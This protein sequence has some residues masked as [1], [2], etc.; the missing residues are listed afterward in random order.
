MKNR[1]ISRQ[2]QQLNTLFQSTR[3]ATG[4]NIELQSH[5]ARYLCVLAAGLLE[6]ALVELYSKYTDTQSSEYVTNFVVS[7]LGLG[8]IQNPKT[9]RFLSVAGTFK[10]QWRTELEKYVNEDGRREAIDSIMTNRHQIAH[11]NQNQFNL[12]VV[13]LREYVKKASDVLDFIENQLDTE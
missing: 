12:S 11:G 8:R 9:E 7:K 3:E 4:D 1:E 2:L 5:W 6:N 10:L 13:R